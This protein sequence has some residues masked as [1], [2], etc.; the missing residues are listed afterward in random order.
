M[1]YFSNFAGIQS[2]RG[3]FSEGFRIK[4][5]V[6]PVRKGVEDVLAHALWLERHKGPEAAD[7]YIDRWCAEHPPTIVH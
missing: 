2:V 1:T 6:V 4:K 5:A 3:S 7:D